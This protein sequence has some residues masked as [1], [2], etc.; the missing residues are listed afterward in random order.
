[1]ILKAHTFELAGESY[2]IGRQI[3]EAVLNRPCSKTFHLNDPGIVGGF[4]A[5]EFQ[6]A[7]ALFEQWCPGL[8]EEL[9]G[10]AD[11]LKAPAHKLAY[12]GMTY[13]RPRPR[14]SQ[15]AL[16]SSMTQCGHPLLAR[17]YEF[18]HEAEDFCLVKTITDNKYAHMGTS[19]MLFGRDDGL[20]EHGLA[21]TMSSCGFPVGPLPYMRAPQLAGL[22]FWAVIRAVLENCKDVN[23]ALAYIEHMPIAYNL[24]MMLVDKTG[25]IALVGTLDGHMA[26]KILDN[27]SAPS[28]LHATN[29][30]V[31]Q[32]LIPF[33]PKAMRHSLVRYDWIRNTIGSSMVT[34]DDLKTMLLAEFPRGL[35]C[36]Y[37]NDFFGTTKSMVIDPVCGIIDLC[38]GGNSRNGWREYCLE[39][40][41]QP[42][43]SEIE[44]SFE[45][46][47]PQMAEYIPIKS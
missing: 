7:L 23:E 32:D 22:Q 12:Y 16:N 10:F 36:H 17:N 41:L 46:F 19:V 20:N 43:V 26:V 29:H 45:R 3:G 2:E 37:F 30:P 15:I 13:L 24:N 39:E 28:Y 40:Q 47:N 35:C 42:S 33:E 6:K 8:N 9:Q 21:V 38:W 44:I 18:S 4:D 34:R 31:H 11:T 5:K 14:C 25:H 1:M 27:E